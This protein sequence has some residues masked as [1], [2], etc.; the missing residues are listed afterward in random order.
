M[1]EVPDVDMG[2][3]LAFFFCAVITNLVDCS[4][5]D[6]G[7]ELTYLKKGNDRNVPPTDDKIQVNEK[8]NSKRLEFLQQLRRKNTAMAMEV[9]EKLTSDKNAKMLLHL[10]R[11][12]MPEMFRYF[13]QRFHFIQTQRTNSPNLLCIDHILA[14]LSVN[15]SLAI[16]WKPLVH[17]R[18]P[19]RGL[20]D[21]ALRSINACPN[22]V[23]SLPAC[24]I[25]FDIFMENTMDGKHLYA[26]SAIDI[27]SDLTKTLQVVNQA[28]WQEAFQ[29]LWIS[30]L[31]LVQ[32]ERELVEGPVPHLDARLCI[33]L[34]VTPLA[35][36]GVIKQEVGMQSS[37]GQDSTMDVGSG[38]YDNYG[39]NQP[40]SI[41]RGLKSSIQLLRQFSGLLS[42]PPSIVSAANSAAQKAATFVS[43]LKKSANYG[44]HAE[45]SAEAVGTMMHLIVEACIAR[46]LLDTSAYLWLGYVAMPSTV[47]PSPTPKQ[48]SPWSIFMEGSQMTPSLTNMLVV[49]PAPTVAEI[50]KLHDIALNGSNNE[51]G[52]A[53]R[54]L[55]GASLNRGWNIQ[56][57]VL[58]SVIKLLS[59]PVPSD[60]SGPGGQNQACNTSSGYMSMIR[61]LLF[62]LCRA[63]ILYIIS[64]YGRVPDV[65]AALLPLCEA[66]GSLSPTST[67]RSTSGEEPSIYSIFSCA[68]LF[69]LRLWK[70]YRPPQEH[71]VAGR[72]GPVRTEVTL[73]Y[74]LL[75]YNSSRGA[76]AKPVYISSFPNLES[77]YLQNQAC[78]AGPPAA[79]RTHQ[80]ANQILTM[81]CRK[82]TSSASSCG[83][84][85]SSSDDSCPRPCLPA[86]EMME[87]IPVVLEALLAAC[88]HGRLSSRELT[89]GL[90]DLVDFLP[91]SLGS[92][93]SYFSSEITRGVWRPVEMNGVDWPSPHATLASIEQEI[94]DILASAG[95]HVPP[96][97][98]PGGG[99]AVILPLPMAALIS[100]T[101]T[102]KLDPAVEY[103]SGVAGPA[104]ENCAANCASPCMPV[105]GALWTQKVRRWHD[106]IVMF[107]AR[108]CFERDQ[109]A[110][111][112]LLGSCF[113]AFLGSSLG[114]R[115]GVDGLLGRAVLPRGSSRGITPGIL[116]L[117]SCRKFYDPF[118]LARQLLDLVLASNSPDVAMLGASLLCIAGGPTLV[119]ILYAE[120][121]P[122]WLLCSTGHAPEGRAAAVML[123]LAAAFVWGVGQRSALW[124][125]SAGL[126]AVVVRG[127]AEFLAGRFTAECHPPAW[128]AYVSQWLLLVVQFAPQWVPAMGP[129]ALRKL[130]CGL[131]AWDKPELALALLETSGPLAASSLFFDDPL[132]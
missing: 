52:A 87:S 100:L 4:L 65:A 93:V 43:N 39:I 104:L 8:G 25:P 90:R 83:S 67:H 64:V 68:F 1:F 122:T 108:N 113:A 21:L 5:E 10:L 109:A 63:D 30:A 103:I 115:G 9:A 76:D 16:D 46:N 80:A 120:T 107:C 37:K 112:Q 42:P 40:S 75:M 127:H 70:F 79:D 88:A 132:S 20:D 29:A 2:T 31:R 91:A 73:D 12:K 38:C 96:S 6:L 35:I 56:E 92:I 130:V 124:R 123:F 51:R 97:R 78:V 125:P 131:R 102:F 13:L 105:I 57:H 66:F 81:L 58:N 117:R 7:L 27:L 48:L 3:S 59:S 62:G 26:T 41:E 19:P 32:R 106:F 50:K 85:T 71:S 72:W 69:L 110:T 119:Q 47:N 55:C 99:G 44:D 95:V 98:P 36:V 121:V 14:K 23:G 60:I 74:L 114:S 111:C 33:L 82:M 128:R 94:R 126:R 11:H 61:P 34:S 18:V 118:F 129:D 28:S 77:W 49:T 54:I 116:Y 22:S 84:S 15:I 86:W 17:K 89:T 24:W 101:I 45:T 53:A